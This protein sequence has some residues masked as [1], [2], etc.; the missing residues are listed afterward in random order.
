MPY[1][2]YMLYPDILGMVIINNKAKY[3]IYFF[4]I[5]TEMTIQ[6]EYLGF[7]WFSKVNNVPLRIH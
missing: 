5:T 2:V 7:K 4:R 1:R 3:Y 6:I